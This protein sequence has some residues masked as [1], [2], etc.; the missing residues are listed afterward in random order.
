[1]PGCE[2]QVP[3]AGGINDSGTTKS[4]I[5]SDRSGSDASLKLKNAAMSMLLASMSK[6]VNQTMTMLNVGA[7]G[8]ASHSVPRARPLQGS[9]DKQQKGGRNVGWKTIP[10]R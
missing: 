10:G 7:K 9:N 6:G 5:G 3:L 4:G 8:K 2:G 1:M